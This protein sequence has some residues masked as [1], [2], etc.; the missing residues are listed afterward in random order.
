MPPCSDLL[1]LGAG[2]AYKASNC[3]SGANC[4]QQVRGDH[5]A[6]KKPS[7][8]LRKAKK[9]ERTLPLKKK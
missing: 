7:K 2:I 1:D 5:M 9:L 3:P 4:N 8:Q 6:T